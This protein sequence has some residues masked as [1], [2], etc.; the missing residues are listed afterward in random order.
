VGLLRGLYNQFKQAMQRIRSR[1][2]V[3]WS[4]LIFLYGLL[5]MEIV[6][7]VQRSIGFD[8][9]NFVSIP[10]FSPPVFMAL[11]GVFSIQFLISL[12][13]ITYGFLDT[14]FQTS[15]RIFQWNST[16]TKDSVGL[17]KGL[18][19]HFKT[20][21]GR[22]RLAGITLALIALLLGAYMNWCVKMREQAARNEW[23]RN[24]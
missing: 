4:P 23:K 16:R 19:Q 15:L 1:A 12:L 9:D 21:F 3:W 2:G 10:P 20:R 8:L 13:S 14:V 17:I 7:R 6:G 18:C 11:I 5:S 22:W 24:L